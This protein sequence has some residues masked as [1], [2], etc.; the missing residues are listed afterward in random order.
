[1]NF[2][3]FF[4]LSTVGIAVATLNELPTTPPTEHLS[5]QNSPTTTVAYVGQE[6]IVDVLDG[7]WRTEATEWLRGMDRGA[8][9]GF[10]GGGVREMVDTEDTR[11]RLDAWRRLGACAAWVNGATFNVV[12]GNC[13]LS[14]HT[15]VGDGETLRVRGQDG[16]DHPVLDR[17]GAANGETTV[18]D[19]H[20]VMTGT[21]NLALVNLKL[22]GAW[23]GNSDTGSMKCGRCQKTV[24]KNDVLLTGF[25]F[26]SFPSISSK[27]V[28]KRQGI[29][30]Q[31]FFLLTFVCLILI[32]VPSFVV[33]VCI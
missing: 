33:A 32:I 9:A 30:F 25:H 18:T 8:A 28:Q 20:F 4:L 13:A 12:G 3:L 1:M 26:Y 23:V 22:I 17:G 2:S 16:L 15:S 27:M 29:Y 5:L 19:R 7:V 6:K 10:N 24:S 31:Y 11:R 14:T 21:S